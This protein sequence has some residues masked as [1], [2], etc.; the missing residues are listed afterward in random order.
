MRTNAAHSL[1]LF[2]GAAGPAVPGLVSLLKDEDDY[3]RVVA[4]HALASV[5]GTA[6]A[7]DALFEM[8]GDA[9][10]E[11]RKAALDALERAG[12]GG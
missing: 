4:A 8:S 7:R 1:A 9:D 10:G 12:A 11:V 3:V 2:G 6:A 5:G